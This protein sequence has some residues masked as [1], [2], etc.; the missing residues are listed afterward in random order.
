VQRTC[1]PLTE[2]VFQ[3]EGALPAFFACLDGAVAASPGGSLTC[4]FDCRCFGTANNDFRTAVGMVKAL[5]NGY[6]ERLGGAVILGAPRLFAALW[7]IISVLLDARTSSKVRFVLTQEE[8]P[9][10]VGAWAVPPALGGQDDGLQAHM[11][12]FVDAHPE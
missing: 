5:Q 10:V 6:P 9:G 12:A 2:S 11:R 4:I 7:R 8:L 1:L 3:R